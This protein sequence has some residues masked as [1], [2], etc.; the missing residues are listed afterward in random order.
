[1]TETES[2]SNLW[3]TTLLL[4]PVASV[5]I[6]LV[7]GCQPMFTSPAVHSPKDYGL[8]T[9]L[10]SRTTPALAHAPQKAQEKPRDNAPEQPSVQA[11][12][13]QPAPASAPVVVSNSVPPPVQVPVTRP[14]VSERPAE[15]V[16]HPPRKPE[17]A[18]KIDLAAERASLLQRDL[19]FSQISQQKGPSEA[20]Y[21]L[22]SADATLLREGEPPIK[23]KEAIRVRM[24]AGQQGTLTWKPE[25]ATVSA[26]ADMGF[27][28]GT[29]V[30]QV[31]GPERKTSR[32]Q[33]VTIWEKQGGQWKIVLWS[34][35]TSPAPPPRRSDL[36]PQ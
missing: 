21:E 12:V 32:G 27:T 11:P 3:R 16:D 20:F 9:P 17:P 22:M 34:S 4:A 19:A 30:F 23:G 29:Y 35:S 8:V 26:Q 36:G 24:A 25:E 15:Q 6:C 31:Q 18:A 13:Q 10:P 5:L 14:P 33:Y 28:W 2:N 1:M 7:C